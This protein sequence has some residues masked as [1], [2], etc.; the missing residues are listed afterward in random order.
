[1]LAANF[2]RKKNAGAGE[3]ISINASVS[4]SACVVVAVVEFSVAIDA[5]RDMF[6][7]VPIRTIAA[8]YRII[9]RAIPLHRNGKLILRSDR[10]RIFDHERPSKLT[11]PRRRNF[12]HRESRE[13]LSGE[14]RFTR[15]R[16]KG[17]RVSI[18]IDGSS[19]SSLGKPSNS[20]WRK[21]VTRLRL[22][23]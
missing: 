11:T 18:P 19:S 14:T 21:R 16:K 2:A 22:R 12:V 9:R 4:T 17:S 3:G 15:D 7:P 20:P 1:M 5:R 8:A 23:H 6:T 13:S 10:F